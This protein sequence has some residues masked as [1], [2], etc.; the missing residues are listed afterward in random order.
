MVQELEGPV[1]GLVSQNCTCWSRPPG[2][3]MQQ[4]LVEETEQE[5]WLALLAQVLGVP[6]MMGVKS[7]ANAAMVKKDGIVNY[8]IGTGN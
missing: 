7:A 1:A 6:A 2:E 3:L 4:V 5:S 8:L